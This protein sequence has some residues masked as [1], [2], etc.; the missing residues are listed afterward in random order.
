MMLLQIA[1]DVKGEAGGQKSFGINARKRGNA[2]LGRGARFAAAQCGRSSRGLQ[3][4][5]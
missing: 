1:M 5:L 4:P 3:E 2:E